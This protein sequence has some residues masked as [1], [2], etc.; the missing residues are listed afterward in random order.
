MSKRWEEEKD[1]ERNGET[2]SESLSL[3]TTA[4][5]KG[6]FSFIEITFAADFRQGFWQAKEGITLFYEN[7]I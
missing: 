4:C 5:I 7:P 3:S 1:V 6:K 2:V